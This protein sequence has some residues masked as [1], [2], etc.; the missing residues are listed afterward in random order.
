MKT[1]GSSTGLVANENPDGYLLDIY[2][3]KGSQMEFAE[4]VHR[5]NYELTCAVLTQS[6]TDSPEIADS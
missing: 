6:T 5:F 1:K 4:F 3:F 2:L